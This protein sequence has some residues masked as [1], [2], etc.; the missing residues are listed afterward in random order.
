MSVRKLP[1]V[2]CFHLKR[3][4]HGHKQRARKLDVPIR[5]PVGEWPRR[6]ATPAPASPSGR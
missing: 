2:L 3:F 1:P 6:H 4:E 5:F